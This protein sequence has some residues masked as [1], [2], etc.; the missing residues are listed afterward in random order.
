[1]VKKA[2]FILQKWY[3]V[4][5]AICI[6]MVAFFVASRIPKKPELGFN[7]QLLNPNEFRSSIPNVFDTTISH[8]EK[9]V[10]VTV[11]R[12]GVS[13]S[14]QLPLEQSTIK[15]GPNL[16]AFS[17][18]NG[19]ITTEYSMRRDGL[20]ENII[21]NKIPKENVFP[22]TLKTQGLITKI[23]AEGI[24][25][26]FDKD[27]KYQFHFER[28]YVKDGNGAMSYAVKYKVVG[29]EEENKQK[30]QASFATELLSSLHTIT[31]T[32]QTYVLQVEVDSTWLHDPKRVLP[33]TIDPTVVHN[34]TSTF[35]TGTSNGTM[36]TGSGATPSVEGYYQ[37]LSTDTSTVGLWH[38]NEASGNVLDS[39]GNGNTGTPTGTSVVSGL[40]GNA[41][42]F[43]GSTDFISVPA[44]AKLDVQRLTI[45]AWTYSTNYI[46]N[47][48]IF[49]KTTNGLVNTQYS[50]FFAASNV[51]IFR[52][53]NTVPTIDDLSIVTS[54]YSLDNKW[55]HIA[56]VYDGATKK[57]Y[58]N[59]VEVASK[60]YSQT[61]QTNAAGTAIIG[62]YGSGTSYFFN[63]KID[64]VRVS[65]VARSPEEIKAHASRR[66]HA[67][68]TSPVIDLGTKATAWNSLTWSE[69]GVSTGYGE[70][71]YS[72]TNLVAQWNLNDSGLTTASVYAGSC[73]VACNGTLTGFSNLSGPDVLPLS[74]WTRQ[75]QRWGTAAVMFDGVDDYI[76]IPDQTALDA[77]TAVTVEAWV[78]PRTI[79]HQSSIVNK[80]GSGTDRAYVL[81][82]ETT[83]VPKF[84]ISTTGSNTVVATAITPLKANNWYYLVGAYDGTNVKI[85]V[86]GVLEGI[87]PAS[88]TIFNSTDQLEIGWIP[89]WAS[90]Y[91]FNGIIDSTRIY[92]RALAANEILSNYNASNLEFQTR[93]GNTAD[94]TDGTWEAWK[95][96]TSESTVDT[97]DSATGQWK[98]DS[99]QKSSPAV[100][101]GGTINLGTGAD[102][103]C[104]M[105]NGT[106]TLDSTAGSSVCNGSARATA[107][108]VNFSD[109]TL[110]LAG[111]TSVT[112]STTPT[113]L[114]AGDE[115]IIIN[116]QGTSNDYQSV[117]E[118]ETHVISSISTNTLNFTDYP[119]SNTYDGTTQK[120]MVQRVP[121][122]GAVTI[123]GGNTG[124]GCTA[125]ATLT[126]TAWNGTKNGLLFFRS[127]GTLTNNGTITM[128]SKGFVGGSPG[129]MSIGV[130]NCLLDGTSA[131]GRAGES[132][133]GQTPLPSCNS[134]AR[135]NNV[136]GGSG[137]V[138]YATWY[139][140]FSVE[141]G[142]GGSY[143]TIGTSG[144]DGTSAIGIP[145]K[146]YGN[147]TNV[148]LGSGGGS[149]GGWTGG[150][151]HV[152][153]LG[154]NGGGAIFISA[155]TVTNN[156]S[157]TSSGGRG[158]NSNADAGGNGAA[159]GGGS[160]G[161]IFLNANIVTLGSNI[162]D[163]IGGIT[164][165]QSAQ[166]GGRC[167]GNGG[168]GRITI[169]YSTSL[170]GST[171]PP[172]YVNKIST[173]L[174][175]EGTGALQYS[176]GKVESDA[177]TIGMWHLDETG[178]TG[179]YLHDSS[180]IISTSCGTG[181]TVTVVD[182]SCV[183]NFTAL[184]ASTFTPLS[185]TTSVAA[186]VVAGG[187][188]GANTGGGGGAGGLVYNTNVTVSATPY[189]ITVGDGGNGG[190]TTGA[191]GTSGS[192]SIFST[193]TATGGGGG[194]S[195]GGVGGANGGSGGGG[196][197]K[198]AAPASTAG[199]GSQGNNGGIGY[200][201]V[202][203]VGNNSGGGGAGAV[204][205]AGSTVSGSGAGGAGLSYSIS[206]TTASYAGG[207]GGG[208]VNGAQTAGAGGSGGGGAGNT[209]GVG[210]AG[211][212][213]TGGGGG[214]GSYSAGVYYNGGKG[215]S[216][217]VIIKYP[218]VQ[219]VTYNHSAP[220]G[221]SVV[222]GIS[223][224]ARSFNGSTDRIEIG[225][226]ISPQN[227]TL[228]AW[229]YR[230]SAT[231]NM[232]IIRKNAAY[233]LSLVSDTIQFAGNP[234]AFSSTGVGIE[235]YKWTHLAVTQDGKTAAIYKNGIK[236]G[237]VTQ[238]GVLA[239]NANQ[240]R[241]GYDDNNWWWGGY[242][243]E[244]RISNIA[245]TPEEIAEA[246]RLGNNH[247][248]FKTIA[249]TDLSTK[250][251]L[252]FYI[253]AD[254]PGTYLNASFGGSSYVNYQ[255]DAN[256]AALFHLDD[257]N[258]EV[259]RSCYDL[260]QFGVVTSGI[261][262]V[263]PDGSGD[264][265]PIQVY[266]NMTYDGGG[267]TMAVKS[268]YGSAMIGKSEAVGA[269]ADATTLMGNAY[270]LADADVRN[271]IGP[272]NNFDVMVDQ[273]G[274][275]ALYSAGNYEFVVLRNYTGY[276]TYEKG[277]PASTTATSFQSYRASD[278]ALAWTGDIGCGYNA[279]A[280]T[281]G[282][283]CHGSLGVTNNPQG[284]AGCV[285]N[286]GTAS[287]AGWYHFFMNQWNDDTYIYICNGAQH[288]SG[289][290]M[291][292]RFWIREKNPVKAI[293]KNSAEIPTTDLITAT[294]GTITYVDGYKIHTFT[295]SGTFQVTAGKGD[296]ET[297]IVGGGAGGGSYVGGGGGGGG[298]YEGSFKVVPASYTVTVGNGGSGG[299]G[300]GAADNANGGN[301]TVVGGTISLTA[302][303][304]GTGS[305][306]PDGAGT[307]GGSGGG[308]GGCSA[309]SGAGGAAQ[310]P[311]SG[312]GG[313]GNAGGAMSAVAR[314]GN[315]TEG[316]GGGGSGS[317]IAATNCSEP[318]DGGTG[319]RSSLSGTAYYYGGGGGGGGFYPGDLG[320]TRAGNGGA[321]GGGGGGA[322]ATGTPGAGGTGG[323]ANGETPTLNMGTTGQGVGGAGGVNTGGGGGGC[324]HSDKGGNGGSGI[325]IIRYPSKV[326]SERNTVATGTTLTQGKVGKARYFNGTSD[327]ISLGNPSS[328]QITGSQ[329]IE[330]WLYPTDLTVRRNPFAKA[331]G[332][333][334]TI[335][336]ETTGILTYYYGTSGI[337]AAPYTG[338]TSSAAITANK[339][340]HIAVVRDLS[341]MKVYWY[342]NGQQTSTAT[343][344]YSA[345]T[346]GTLP[347]YIGTGYTNLYMGSIDEVRISNTARTASDIRQT[348]EATTRSHPITIDFG[349]KLDSG[350]L[351]ANSGDVSFT[352]DATTFGLNQKGSNIYPDDKII[353]RE[354][355]DGTEYI[356]QG[357][358][359][360]A[361]AAT[362]AVNILSWDAGS[363][364]PASG[365]TAN[366]DVFKW[367]RE[368]WNITDAQFDSRNSVKQLSLRLT[369]GN[370]GRTIWLDDIKSTNGY[371]TIPTGSSIPS[372]VGNR[373]FQYR[374]IFSSTDASLSAKLTSV[375]LNYNANVAPTT[376]SLDSPPKSTT[377]VSRTPT[378]QTTGTDINLD[379][380]RYKIQ[381]CT[382]AAMTLNC[383]T[384]DQTS[385]QTGWSA[386]NAENG[387]AYTTGMQ[388]SY[389]LQT[390]L[391][392]VTTY[393]WRSYAIDP[394]GAN[395]WTGTQAT[396]F[397]FTTTAVEAASSCKS[398]RTNDTTNTIE[399]TD[400][401]GNE[402]GYK[403]QRNVD[404][405]GWVDLNPSLNPN[406]VSYIDST[407]QLN[408]S[409]QYRIAPFIAG[410]QYGAWCTTQTQTVNSSVFEFGGG[411]NFS[412]ITIQ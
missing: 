298:V 335:T 211:T 345:A 140:P 125:A 4:F 142:S 307:A 119:L 145:G 160:G 252:P 240:T 136:G 222:N 217:I 339:W 129:G 107:Y 268:W 2:Y 104:I 46:H 270:K 401:S 294:G 297:L 81:Y 123:C 318:G 130:D 85:Y 233:A 132:I 265:A 390:P 264:G 310:Q 280:G 312:T 52:T 226:G 391:N 378:L 304:G 381:L 114:A 79:D 147:N 124:G 236:I 24:P 411:F 308:A 8:T 86:N 355:Y 54:A 333:E 45:E 176:T 152:G 19:E 203:W 177:G 17:S 374:T 216:G 60:A 320:T 361:T 12:E 267:W 311:T 327:L 241:I 249:P 388:G 187:G 407:V 238:S 332:G 9:Q 38:M 78:N 325:V 334:G 198:S 163:A 93:V 158:F 156:N 53:Y 212:T 218:A 225:T 328:L 197:L 223:G 296:V 403:I 257:D 293:V 202:G 341:A 39:S 262:T 383:Q 56:C 87:T 248:I 372:S 329:T 154:G 247:S 206:G 74:G 96:I 315:D 220:T 159:G 295:G 412:G 380:L 397:S 364:F 213:N 384:F 314:S 283:N 313:L 387:T 109:T 22:S 399:W 309:G 400:V 117:G 260:R 272:S 98:I 402:T 170:S 386:Q 75:N 263:D 120:I 338:F 76:S 377:S 358:V 42:S 190:L 379:Y 137:G 72:A 347:A 342:I 359:I 88:G 331:Y 365:F 287:N 135:T 299:S 321:G 204:G 193:I 118:Y 192:N 121:N 150:T 36:D 169:S 59:G 228:E 133:G 367:Q 174:K 100:S 111:D 323:T 357:N 141:G 256:T 199:V 351:I 348:Y 112:V 189:T 58:I 110:E 165:L 300:G 28:P 181:G 227:I 245:R 354:N 305:R 69:S 261:Y 101:A 395:T 91:I 161:S 205:G 289:Q 243:D 288:S 406:T 350:N 191:A 68:Y 13:L 139:T 363:T 286:M 171:L 229:V 49:E 375:T 144:K 385:S 234:W 230:T 20:K 196:A 409:Y 251:V 281:A 70:T 404:A 186:L 278:Q 368:Y 23:S 389:T 10:D 369:D 106:K 115:F 353:V 209:N 105:D 362:G 179:A 30:T 3:I 258:K 138:G 51:F 326:Y 277:M 113:G 126:A 324:G 303:G 352:V 208:P 373:Y 82:T 182:G 89:G 266:C 322:Y 66:P 284:G 376:P 178:G 31:Q 90:A 71:V 44:T 244:V 26:F 94:P 340:N 95:P 34:S 108:A 183:H 200:I 97:L 116:L 242:I 21:L 393:Y 37:E 336:Q 167:G 291:N 301:S 15:E 33:I 250:T 32:G 146:T 7:K 73:G 127:N 398:T 80:Q 344:P 92:S 274:F 185:A 47:G 231:T 253:A 237:N 164:Y 290:S 168:A 275:N 149:A 128:N 394:G 259:A 55:N 25:V 306:F 271:I 408:H 155:D 382:D 84:S 134:I 14:F 48:F 103:A 157:I 6:V 29:Q 173:L 232:G 83:N 153:G 131:H 62:A 61:L 207:G 215:G 27:N 246:Y 255:P 77:S 210:T 50:C 219:T 35:A 269:V 316:R 330:M 349:A 356:A 254:R 5:I 102:G 366:A 65:N 194:S 285:I 392:Y 276:W 148:F 67:S 201:D 166:C 396:P 302:L 317:G 175:Q 360:S 343:A 41:R 40:L 371:L 221:T 370:E 162:V 172:A 195:H 64:E 151:G 63:G 273:N 184:G 16:I 224:K 292:H 239:S 319:R 235:M 43:N 1:M 18:P 279:G 99:N 410:P 57:I 11:N 405:A 180:G 188:G 214:G 122:F 337:N 143:G 346:A 282:I